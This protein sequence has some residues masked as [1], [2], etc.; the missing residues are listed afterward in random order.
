VAYWLKPLIISNVVR[1]Q[2]CSSSR[3]QFSI[4]A[5]PESVWSRLANVESWWLKSNP[6]HIFLEIGS[7]DKS[8][9][10]GTEIA[11]GERVAGITA[12]ASGT[13]TSLIP[14]LAATWEGV[15]NYRYYG[16]RFAIQEGVPGALNR[17]WAAR[18]CPLMCGHA[19]LPVP[20]DNSSN[21]IP[22]TFF[23]SLSVIAS[24]LDASSNT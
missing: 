23:T 13:V 22:C 2:F 9:V 4:R 3:S 10:A 8:V 6:E 11:F 21:G 15:A 14:G 12:R 20:S 7:P 19:F 17:T 18:F 24:T 5:T 16:F 1:G